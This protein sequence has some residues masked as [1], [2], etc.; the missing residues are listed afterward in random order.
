MAETTFRTM[1]EILRGAIEH[2]RESFEEYHDAALQ[3]EDPELR[4]FLMALAEME[5]DHER[6][7]KAQL[8]RLENQLWVE[9]ALSL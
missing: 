9:R 1:R 6:Q 4:R 2:E 3:A 7:L 5:K 8:E